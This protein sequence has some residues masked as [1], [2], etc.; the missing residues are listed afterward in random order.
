MKKFLSNMTLNQ[1]LAS[2]ALLLG[3]L[4]LILGNPFNNNKAVID[5]KQLAL[6]VERAQDHV[7]VE[8]LADWIMKNKSDFKLI[9]IRTEKEFS[10]YHIPGALNVPVPELVN[11]PY[12][13]NSKIVIYSEAGIH[14]VQAWYLMR[15]RGYRSVYFIVGGLDEWKSKVLFPVRPAGNAPLAIAQFNKMKEVSKFFGGTPQDSSAQ[16]QTV[17][18]P[19]LSMPSS[20]GGG[21]AAPA[22]GAKKKKEGC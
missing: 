8:E 7:T 2:A 9:D 5:L 14:S 15:A 20:A 4:A 10:E 16:A 13:K 22:G 6:E 21:T 1:K 18:A 3:I 17:A 19:K 12:E 11:Q